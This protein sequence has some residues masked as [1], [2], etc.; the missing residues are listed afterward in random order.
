[1]ISAILTDTVNITRRTDWTIASRDVLNNP[2][3]GDPITWNIVY[4]NI[5][6]RLAW[7]GKAMEIKSTGELIYPAGTMYIPK[8]YTV[9]PMDRVVTVSTPG[10]QSGIE[11]VIESV[12]PAF[13]ANGLVDHYEAHLHLPL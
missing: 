9:Q 10:Y 11:Y 13:Y 3:Y 1:M 2:S 8:N 12:I 5:K 6:V 4:S 7:S